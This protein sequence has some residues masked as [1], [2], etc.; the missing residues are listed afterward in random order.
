MKKALLLAPLAFFLLFTGCKKIQQLL[1]FYVDDSQSIR[2]PAT[3]LF[4]SVVALTPLPVAT[5]SDETFKNNNTRA[6][7]VKDVSLNKL[8]LTI[9]DPSGQNFDFLQKIE[10]D[11]ST[12]ANDQIRLAYLDAV[13]RNATSID[14]ISTD[15]RLDTYLKASSYTLTTK[16]QTNQAL[17]REVTVRAD[18]RFKVTADP[19]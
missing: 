4:G 16:V 12:N 15:A 7:L 8:S 6:D 10:I 17:A 5:K 11:I 1:T 13:P 18:S 2:I 19:L 9:T 14:L 3:P